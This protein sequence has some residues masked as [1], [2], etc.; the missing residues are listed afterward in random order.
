MDKLTI[1]KAIATGIVG[2]GT[3]TIVKS[4]VKNNV[5]PE[6]VR[7][8]IYIGSAL[9]VISGMAAEATKSYTDVRIDSLVELWKKVSDNLNEVDEKDDT[10][11]EALTKNSDVVDV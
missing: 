1:A 9:F 2:I 10:P 5:E 7:Q 4:I 8:K 11:V 3:N 6:N